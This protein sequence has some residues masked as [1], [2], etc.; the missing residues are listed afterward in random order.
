[1][2]FGGRKGSEAR[3][4]TSA[5]NRAAGGH[6]LSTCSNFNA[7]W[8]KGP[9]GS[10]ACYGGKRSGATWVNGEDMTVSP[11]PPAVTAGVSYW[12]RT[13][14]LPC[15][16]RSICNLKQ[17]KKERTAR[18]SHRSNS[19]IVASSV[20]RRRRTAPKTSAEPILVSRN[21]RS[22]ATLTAAGCSTGYSS[23]GRGGARADPEM[24]TG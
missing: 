9:L 20:H 14:C 22:S 12:R 6:K 3:D 15:L 11:P 13:E 5:K 24:G 4:R 7:F 16:L 18:P 10:F 21:W 8:P 2:P 1:M 19:F 23:Q 17:A